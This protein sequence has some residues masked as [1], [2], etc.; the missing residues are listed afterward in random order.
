[1]RNVLWL[2]SWYPNDLA[3]FDGDFIQRHAQSVA[4]LHRV[5]VLHIIND[6][7]GKVT[8]HIKEKIS[9]KGN[10]TERIIYY[11]SPGTGISF[12]DK[13]L[14][15]L[16]YMRLYKRAIQKYIV[17]K[18][19]PS[20]V[21]VHV[22]M[23]AGVIALWLNQKFGIPYILSEHWTDYLA[24]AKPN[25]EDHSLV[26]KNLCKKI[27]ERASYVTVVSKVLGEAV[28]KK[29]SIQYSVIPNVVDTSIFFPAGHP[30]GEKIN[31]IHVSSLGY[32]KNIPQLIGAIDMVKKKGHDFSVTIFGPVNN[33]L[34]DLL[35]KYD[36]LADV[37]LNKEVPQAVLA[38]E[39]RQSDALILYSRYETFGCVVIE[40]NASGV[41]AILSDLPVFREYSIENKTAIFAPANNPV[42][43][44]NAM[45]S[46][47]KKKNEFDPQKISDH[48]ASKFN[49]SVVAH[50]FDA[51]Y[52]KIFPVSVRT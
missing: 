40:A 48:V 19:K 47:M 16:K 3:P 9:T 15:S 27:F 50:R 22:A 36:L 21:H 34:N 52:Q 6:E 23:K 30:P 31:F 10:L 49:Y 32:Q 24:E 26:F 18:G 43:L 17:V 45:I 11:R 5:E 20:I 8:D 13:L 7:S 25:F 42:E 14:S 51:L 1:M 28:A 29:F 46:F 2:A 39:F 44:A 33:E 4:L 35:L 37:S 12:L 41:P 38:K